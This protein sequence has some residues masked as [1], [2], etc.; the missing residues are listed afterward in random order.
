MKALFEEEP[1]LRS[2]LRFVHIGPS[3]AAHVAYVG[4]LGLE[5][6][7]EFCGFV[8]HAEAVKRICQADALFFCLADSPPGDL[9]D[10]I[11]QKAFEYIAARRPVLALTPPGD[12]HDLF[13]ESGMAEVCPP[14]DIP[15]IVSAL[16]RLLQS[17]ES[18]QPN[19]ALRARFDRRNL[20]K[21]L[22]T[23]LDGL[24]SHSTWCR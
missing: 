22:A 7:V 21:Q 18:M 1:A 5:E 10:C 17:A 3:S 20:T 23:I 24:T 9:N 12:A 19:E 6:N 13:L 4:K 2:K 16:R 15:A 8:P 11:P 14:R